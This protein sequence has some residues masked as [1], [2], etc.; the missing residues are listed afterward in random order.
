MS[1]K[2]FTPAKIGTLELTNRLIRSATQDP[3]GQADGTACQVQIDLHSE[4]AGSGVP[5]II[6][7]YTYVSPEGRATNIQV[8][9]CNEAHYAC[10][11]KMVDAVH[12]KGGKIALQIN[13]AGQNVYFVPTDLPD[14]TPLAPSG[15]MKAPN[16]LMTRE[17]STAD[18][19]RLCTD[20]VTAAVKGKEL[21]FDAV[22]LHCAHGYLLNQFMDPNYNKREDEFG[23]SAENRFRFPGKILLALREALGQD[24]PILVKVNS[25]CAG[26]ADAAYAEDIVYF[27][28]QFEALGVNAIELSGFDWIA[29]GKKKNHN[30]YLER[31]KAVHAAV[32]TPI[33]FV[34]GVRT[35]EDIEAVLDA[36][37][38]FVS[39]ARPFIAQ[40]DLIKHL[41]AGEDAKCISCSKCFVLWEREGRRCVLHDKPEA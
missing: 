15:N 26:E 18:I 1:S 2:L 9:F 28:Q 31:A 36:G 30:Y 41:E 22:Q 39:L 6:T 17:I 20:Y 25:N 38:D 13:H 21:G 33:I 3:F 34:G 4:I 37:M 10:Q 27:C 7:A 32:K 19:E 5:L 35:M 24:Y 11:K 16:G 12:E 8:G 29:Q 14:P 40:P 23:G